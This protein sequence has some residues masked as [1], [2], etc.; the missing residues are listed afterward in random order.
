MTVKQGIGRVLYFIGTTL[1]IVAPA[2]YNRYPLMYFDSGAYM[3]MAATLQPSFHRAL[4][5]PLL[6]RLTGWLVSNWPIVLL[7]GFLLSALLF[8]LTGLLFLARQRLYHFYTVL[9]LSFASSMSWYAAQVMPDVFTLILAL[10][11]IAVILERELSPVRMAGYAM[12]VFFSLVTHLSHIPLLALVLVAFALT[13]KFSL[14]LTRAKWLLL[15]APL[16]AAFLATC[17][18]NAAHGMGFRLSLASNVF[19]TANLGEMG[20]LK[21]YLDENC[22]ELRSGLCDLKDTLPLETGG[23][24]W[25][26]DSP[27]QTNPGGWKAANGEYAPI[28]HDFLLKPRYLKWF[29]F[30]AVKATFKQMFQIELGSGL[31]YKYGEGSPPYWQMKAHFPQ[32]LNEY[33][34]SVQNKGDALPIGFFRVV[35]YLGLLLSLGIIGRAVFTGRV[36]QRFATILLLVVL[37]YFF[38]AA[39]TGVLANVYERLQCRLVPLFQWMALLAVFWERESTGNRVND[40]HRLPVQH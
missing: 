34:V 32:E 11:V 17:I 6:M 30:G 19:I 39:V 33:L 23:Y 4:G 28:V 29:V 15:C 36:D 9:I 40:A 22:G 10:A 24:L 3:E 13:R 35:Q 26:A 25:T 5:Y 20:I 37:F 18:Y 16:L 7:Q 1:L 12:L 2:F 38:N 27:V 14:P 31:Q 8:R 21:T